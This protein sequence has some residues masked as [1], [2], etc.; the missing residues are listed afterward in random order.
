MTKSSTDIK[1]I[2]R[3]NRARSQLVMHRAPFFGVL[4]L[5]LNLRASTAFPTC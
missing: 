1:G 4:A 3:V 2:L 5:G